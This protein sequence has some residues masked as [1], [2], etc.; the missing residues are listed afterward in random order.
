[1]RAI[2][3]TFACVSLCR[4]RY[5]ASRDKRICLARILRGQV[6]R[7]R[8]LLSDCSEYYSLEPP[9]PLDKPLLMA[10]SEKGQQRLSGWLVPLPFHELVRLDSRWQLPERKRSAPDV[11]GRSI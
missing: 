10:S 1:M 7:T 9:F 4:N 8:G 6:D 5:H 3:T 2:F 11:L